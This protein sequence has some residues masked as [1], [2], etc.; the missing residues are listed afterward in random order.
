MPQQSAEGEFELVCE[1][2][3]AFNR[4]DIGATLT[5]AGVTTTLGAGI[6]TLAE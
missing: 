5:Y 6:D 1:T 2:W 3:A 4:D